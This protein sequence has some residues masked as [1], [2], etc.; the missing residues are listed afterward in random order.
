M[1]DRGT[2]LLRILVP[3]GTLALVLIAWQIAANG[4]ETFILPSP[5]Q[6]LHALIDDWAILGPSLWVTVSLTLLALFIALAGGVGL[7]VLMS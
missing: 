6:V 5:V 1:R 2:I 3:L 7:A 4:T